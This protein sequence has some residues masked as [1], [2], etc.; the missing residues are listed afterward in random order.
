MLVGTAA[1][2]RPIRASIWPCAATSLRGYSLLPP[3]ATTCQHIK[4]AGRSQ[5]VNAFR[6]APKPDCAGECHDSDLWRTFEMSEASPFARSCHE[7]LMRSGTRLRPQTTL[8]R[9][10]RDRVAPR[11]NLTVCGCQLYCNAHDLSL[12]SPP[13]SIRRPMSRG[14]AYSTK[15]NVRRVS[16]RNRKPNIQKKGSAL[17]ACAPF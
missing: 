16:A 11:R 6:A 2:I 15:H 14:P 1:W 13:L 4:R 3:S 9:R 8:H 10:R 7:A 12:L 17:R 5:N